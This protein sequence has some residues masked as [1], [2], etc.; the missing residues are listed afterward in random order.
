MFQWIHDYLTHKDKL[1][2]LRREDAAWAVHYEKMFWDK[3][4]ADSVRR[5][6]SE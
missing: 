5:D 1:R 4:H 2:E 6:R 3:V